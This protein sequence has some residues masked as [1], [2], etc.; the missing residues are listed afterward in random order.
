M[1]EQNQFF[2]RLEPTER[3]LD[4]PDHVP[5]YQL[6][7]HTVISLPNQSIV[8]AGGNIWSVANGQVVVNGVAD[9]TTA[10]VIEMAYENGLVWQKNANNLWWSK[11]TP[12][13]SWSPPNGTSVD[14]IPRQ[15]A[16]PDNTVLLAGPPG[17]TPEDIL[18]AFSDASGNAWSIANGQVTLN[19]IA[20]PTTAN[21]IGLAYENG[22]I[23]QENAANLWW[24]KT[25]PADQWAPSDGT[26]ASPVQAGAHFEV[27]GTYNF[28][29]ITVQNV[30]ETLGLYGGATVTTSGIQMSGGMLTVASYVDTAKPIAP[31]IVRGDSSLANGASLSVELQGYKRVGQGGPLENDGTMTVSASRLFVGHLSGQG[32]ISATDGSTL[33]IQ[34]ASASSA[35]TIQLTS[36]HLDIGY[37]GV[38]GPPPTNPG[39]SF[40]APITDF[41]PTSSITLFNTQATSEVFAKSSP[42]A[43]EL[44][45]YNGS[46]PVADL[47][48][49]GQANIYA[50]NPS[51]SPSA[52]GSILLTPYDTGHSLPIA[53]S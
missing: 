14:A 13:D 7:G 34:I 27:T 10:N 45:L 46:T 24:S 49:S 2:R 5:L 42:T 12:A 15:T 44:F 32:V 47:H 1:V 17:A 6:R 48:I 26:P 28:G 43:G 29:P 23:W 16:S 38:F 22:Q 21:V 50:S 53:T 35:E 36:A 37:T 39:L 4:Q 20:D 18:P 31:L 52:F 9:P 40:L 3:D 8:D 33:G 51:P 19:G 25:V 41:G 11:G 30:G